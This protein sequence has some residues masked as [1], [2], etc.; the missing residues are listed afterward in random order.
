MKMPLGGIT[1]SL[2]EIQNRAVELSGKHSK[3]IDQF[4]ELMLSRP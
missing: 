4:L 1:A 2:S 3:F